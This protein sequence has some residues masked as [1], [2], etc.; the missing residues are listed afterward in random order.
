[1]SVWRSLY[2]SYGLHL[3]TQRAQLPGEVLL[4]VFLALSVMLSKCAPVYYCL[5]VVVVSV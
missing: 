3:G 1:M 4:W 5:D 2:G